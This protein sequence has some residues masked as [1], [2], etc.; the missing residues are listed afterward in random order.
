MSVAKQF[1]KYRCEVDRG[2]VVDAVDKAGNLKLKAWLKRA[3]A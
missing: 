2:E 3:A 1:V